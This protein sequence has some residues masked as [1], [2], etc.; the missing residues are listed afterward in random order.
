MTKT[1]YSDKIY[2]YL[3]AMKFDEPVEIEFLPNDIIP[4]EV[5][6][7]YFVA[8]VKSFIDFDN[9]RHNGYFIEFNNSFQKIRKIKL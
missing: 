6:K 7:A 9:G 3:S 1:E 5:A 2:G 4:S 8:I